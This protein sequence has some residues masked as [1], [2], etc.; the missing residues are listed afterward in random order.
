MHRICLSIAVWLTTAGAVLSQNAPERPSISLILPPG[1]EV[2]KVQV[3]DVM[4]GPFGGSGEQ[5]QFDHKRGSFAIKPYV[6]G[7]P[8]ETVKAIVFIPGCEIVTF[9]TKFSGTSLVHRIDCIPLRMLTIRGHLAPGSAATRDDAEIQVLY[10]AFWAHQF[11]GIKDGM[12]TTFDLGVAHTNKAGEFEIQIPDFY[13][14]EDLRDAAFLCIARDRRTW[15]LLAFLHPE[16]ASNH[17]NY[18]KVRAK[19]PESMR[20]ED[21]APGP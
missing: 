19:Y 14:Q 8:A 7:K 20:F 13:S 15:N 10:L 11:Y 18:I 1:T 17:D 12:V 9:S 6:E 16:A 3:S 21:E 4:T 5:V 2:T